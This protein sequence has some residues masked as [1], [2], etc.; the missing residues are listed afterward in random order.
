[1]YCGHTVCVL[2]SCWRT[3]GSLATIRT[4]VQTFACLTSKPFVKNLN[5]PGDILKTKS[6]WWDATAGLTYIQVVQVSQPRF[7]HSSIFGALQWMPALVCLCIPNLE[8]QQMCWQNVFGEEER[9]LALHTVWNVFRLQE[10]SLMHVGHSSCK[11]TSV[12]ALSL[13]PENVILFYTRCPNNEQYLKFCYSKIF[14]QS[15]IFLLY[16]FTQLPPPSF[17]LPFFTC[18]T[19]RH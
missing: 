7:R 11:M 17:L 19:C 8:L 9:K 10:P 3:V 4:A 6:P 14:N 1:M 2:S 5:K 18:K 16:I 15:H 13:H 12:N